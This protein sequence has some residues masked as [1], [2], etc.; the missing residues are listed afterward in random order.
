MRIIL[1]L[2]FA[3]QAHAAKYA[4]G[5]KYDDTKPRRSI[6]MPSDIP[7][8]DTYDLRKVKN[9]IPIQNQGNCGSC[10]A[11]ATTA[12]VNDALGGEPL[13]AQ[14]L[15]DCDM[16]SFGCMGGDF[17]AFNMEVVPRGAPTAANYPY[18]ARTGRCVNRGIAG[19]I[20]AWYYI[21]HPKNGPTITDM[22]KGILLNGEI[23]VAMS[24]SE[25]FMNYKRG[26]YK[27][28]HREGLNHMVTIVGWDNEGAKPL[29]N[30]RYPHGKGYW[31]IRNS[32]GTGWGEKG[33]GRIKYSDTRGRKCS[34]VG[35][36]AALVDVAKPL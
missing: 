7:I 30:G 23:A 32:W 22:Q 11:F 9:L 17:T 25:S 12:V 13:S 16:S 19:S 14:Y 27:A 36:V 8:P 28:C 21:G 33:W 20:T 35:W 2:L 29:P 24:A 4:T 34:Q 1:V 10:W 18:R 6:M 31:I 15:V 5:L 3:V 26:V